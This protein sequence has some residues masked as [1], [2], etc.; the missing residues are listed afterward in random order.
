MNFDEIIKNRRSGRLFTS[1]TVSD[2]ELSQI[3]YSGSLAPSAKNRQPWKFY[4]LNDEQKDH[5]T[6]MLFEWDK[7]NP[8]EPTSVK[9]TAEQINSANKMIMIYSDYYKSNSKNKNYKKPDYLSIG[10]ALENMSLQAVNLGLGS[11]ILC[12]TLYVQSE[13][14]NYLGIKGFEQICGFIIGKPIFNYPP[15]IKKQLK[16][17]LLNK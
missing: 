10:C 8:N 12:D 2:E 3:L 9:G 16:D 15:K 17:L 13:I 7:L 5:I 11:C 14:D 4:V 6:N 1:E